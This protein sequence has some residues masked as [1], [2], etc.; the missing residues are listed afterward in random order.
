LGA[1]SEFHCQKLAEAKAQI[2]EGIN[3]SRQQLSDL[4]NENFL[5]SQRRVFE[6]DFLD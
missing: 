5:A 2:L 3:A 6:A 1:Q 4:K